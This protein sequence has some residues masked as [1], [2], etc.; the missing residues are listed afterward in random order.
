MS[1]L[2]KSIIGFNESFADAHTGSYQNA[3]GETVDVRAALS[4]DEMVALQ[5]AYNDYSKTELKAYF[6]GT[7]VSKDSLTRS[8]K[9]AS[10]QLMGAYVIE[11]SRTVTL[12]SPLESSIFLATLAPVMPFFV[13]ILLV[14][15][16]FPLIKA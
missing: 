5:Q 8:Y 10:L 4:F 3:A 14:L 9:D 13:L 12:L 1:N 7:D 15:A 16:Y 11:T 2:Q 6:N